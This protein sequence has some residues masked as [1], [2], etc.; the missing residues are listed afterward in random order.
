MLFIFTIN[1]RICYFICLEMLSPQV[2]R[3]EKIV[4]LA[5]KLNFESQIREAIIKA[6]RG[7]GLIKHLSKYVSRHVLNQ[8]YKIYVRPHLDCSDIIYHIY[9]PEM[10]STFTQAGTNSILSCCSNYWSM[11]RGMYQRCWYHRMCHFF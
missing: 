7:I 11:E 2:I 1:G 4:A 10:Q 8:I 9:K 6:R 5:S 3:T